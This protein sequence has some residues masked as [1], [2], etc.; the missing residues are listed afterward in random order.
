MAR[1]SYDT[2][3]RMI[4]LAG[5]C[6]WYWNGFYS[7]LESSGVSRRTIERY[8]RESFNKYDVMRNV[9]DALED[10]DDTET[11]NKI[12][13]NLYRMKS[14][15]DEGVPDR[16]KAKRLLEEFRA[17]VGNDP[18]EQEIQRRKRQEV[19]E[20]HVVAVESNRSKRQ[21]L[22]D[23]NCSFLGLHVDEALSPQKRGYALENLFCDLLELYEIEHSRPYK[24]EGEQIDGHFRYEKFDYLIETKWESGEIKQSD[25]S[26]FDGKIRGKAQ[27]TRG[28][29]LAAN[30]FDQHA[31]GKFSGDSPRIVLATGED[32]ALILAGQVDFLDGLNAKIAAIVR[33]GRILSPLRELL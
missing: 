31:I 18:I 16:E 25:L 1:I 20:Q 17:A 9:L 29:F 27:S 14:A 10:E 4:Q 26:V 11:I 24:H 13:S 2:K 23:L 21:R 6:F 33:H 5:T 19:R 3:N 15:A 32:L 22:N 28:F 12:V 7:F 8:P 30:G